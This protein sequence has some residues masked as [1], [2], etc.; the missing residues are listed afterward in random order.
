MTRFHVSILLL[1]VFEADKY[2]VPRDQTVMVKPGTFISAMW[3]DENDVERF[4]FAYVVAIREV[5]HSEDP[6]EPVLLVVSWLKTIRSTKEG[7]KPWM[8]KLD[9]DRSSMILS[10][11]FDIIELDCV[12]DIVTDETDEN[13]TVFTYPLA[14]SEQ[15]DGLAIGL[16]CHRW[17]GRLDYFRSKFHVSPARCNHCQ[18]LH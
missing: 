13:G 14:E 5:A 1:Y 17:Y 12:A 3:L 16:N 7:V 4:E 15:T 10:T 11:E 2:P 9:L 18:Q 8:K 6:G